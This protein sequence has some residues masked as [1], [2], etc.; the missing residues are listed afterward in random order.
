M[1]THFKRHI[2]WGA[3]WA[4][5]ALAG[6]VVFA[7]ME[8]IKQKD[9]F[10]AETQVVHR[11]LSQSVTQVEAVLSTLPTLP[12]LR[13]QNERTRAEQ[14]LLSVFPHVLMVLRRD[15]SESWSD[16]PLRAGE[17][18]SRRLKRAVLADVNLAKGRYH[19]VLGQ[20]ASSFALLVDIKTMIPWQDW[21]MSR[22][23]SPVR[24]ALALEPQV[25]VL[26]EGK[27]D[28]KSAQA[29]SNAIS[30]MF[31][32]WTFESLE[33]LASSTQPFSL[34]TSRHVGWGELPLSRMAAWCLLVALMLLALRALLRQRHDRHRAEAL[35][36]VGQAGRLNTLSELATGMVQE[37]GD[38]MRSAQTA[39]Q[40][41][42]QLL[43]QGDANGDA[44]SLADAQAA[45]GQATQ[46]VERAANV[47]NRLRH[48]VEQ[49]DLSGGLSGALRPVSLLA[50]A[51][52][53]LDLVSP[54][55]QRL[56]I[57]QSIQSSQADL[58]VTAE[59]VAL[60][61]VIHNLLINAMQALQA[62]RPSER[63]LTLKLSS[64]EPHTAQLSIQDTGPGIANEVVTHI[65]KPFFTT[66]PG[67]LGLGLSLSET[68]ASSMGGSLTAYN[69]VPR[70]AEFCL[71]LPLAG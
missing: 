54:E 28:G 67:A 4:A 52:G 57:K 68:L 20:E 41:A 37:L 10:E 12:G 36:R 31:R 27:Q 50:A 14:R 71:T 9:A 66:R 63:T 30:N 32:G 60:G 19:L 64:I 7:R 38:P 29:T 46:D 39:M 44:P 42:N 1:I 13:A 55:L 22:D 51:R 8:L 6:C 43:Q 5:L 53:A 40:A 16:E 11:L 58:T 3:A 26:Q 69:R 15:G 35:L 56:S 45:V 70:G 48:V 61:Q 17:A 18:E 33:T 47:M 23:T 62:V 25:M 34:R 24:V 2:P 49:P 21:P 65:F 59:P